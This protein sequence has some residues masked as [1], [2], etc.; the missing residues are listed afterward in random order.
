MSRSLPT[1]EVTNLG[2]R[3]R[4]GRMTPRESLARVLG[5]ART[6]HPENHHW[7]LRK[8]SFTLNRGDVLGVVGANGAGK[9][10]LLKLMSRITHPTEGRALIRGRVGSLLEVGTGF[11]PELTGMENVF[12]NGA[13]LGMSRKEIRSQLANIL[14][15]AGIGKYI[16]T[17]VKRYSS[18]MYTRL[19]FAVAAHLEP[20]V[21]I[22]DEVLAVG[23][24]A[25]QKRCL[26]K[27]HDAAE[28]GRTILF[29]S[30]G[31]GNV[32]KLC[33]KALYLKDGQPEAYGEV[34]AILDRYQTPEEDASPPTPQVTL[35]PPKLDAPVEGLHLRFAN[36]HGQPA[37]RFAL[38]EP[39]SVEL[40]LK[41]HRTLPA[42]VI[43]L[44]MTS[45]DGTPV[46]TCWSPPADLPPGQHRVHFPIELPLKATAL[47]FALGISS[48]DLVHYYAS[49]L[50]HIN[51]GP[52]IAPHI[53]A[54]QKTTAASGL[55]INPHAAQVLTLASNASAPTPATSPAPTLDASSAPAPVSS[56]ETSH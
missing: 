7:A 4:L 12:I 39:F 25:F 37:T 36:T 44:G 52:N 31:A 29:V 10:T 30:H 18:G 20:E 50:G 32:Q 33:N 55:M 22:V 51:I 21:M 27:M 26:D 11:H 38:G 40:D 3:Y 16:D 41:V 24:A 23:D 6:D 49:E 56:T 42:C 9:S 43:A 13:I 53:P 2:K 14:E 35:P 48:N 45:A 17:P 5:R 34:Q 54:L 15:F 19:A 1:V 8:V 47:Q 46:C 28:S